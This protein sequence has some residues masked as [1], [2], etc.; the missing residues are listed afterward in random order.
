MTKS[1]ASKLTQ[2]LARVRILTERRGAKVALAQFLGVPPSSVSEWLKPKPGWSPGGEVTLR[3]LEWVEAEEGNQK[4]SPGR[5]L[6]R[7]EPET[8][9]RKSSN[10]NQTQVR[11]KR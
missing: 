2:L 8:Q 5:A 10:E 7:P 1:S 3:L 9:A 11:K 4:V 6:T